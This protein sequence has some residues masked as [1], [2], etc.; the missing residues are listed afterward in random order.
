MLLNIKASTMAS[1]MIQDLEEL[2]Y[3]EER[4]GSDMVGR[5]WRVLCR[6]SCEYSHFFSIFLMKL[7]LFMCYVENTPFHIL[8]KTS[9]FVFYKHN[10]CT[11]IYIYVYIYRYV[12]SI[13]GFRV[14]IRD[15]LGDFLS[16][17]IL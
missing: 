16:Q 8:F 6:G 15:F 5:E 7:H 13:G 10:I 9:L 14:P 17:K 11:Y 2:D 1:T 3:M 12:C 4:E